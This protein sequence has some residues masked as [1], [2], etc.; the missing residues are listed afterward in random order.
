[1]SLLIVHPTRR[2]CH[3][4]PNLFSNYHRV[5][6]LCHSETD[7]GEELQIQNVFTNVSKGVV[8]KKDELKECFGT[9]DLQKVLL[10]VTACCYAT[11]PAPRCL[12]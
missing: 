5:L 3:A 2:G 8:A 1:L 9:E 10:E 7:L 4:F 6:S 12:T 11:V